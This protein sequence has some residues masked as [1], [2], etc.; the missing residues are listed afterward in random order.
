MVT[1]LLMA[2][3]GLNWLLVGAFDVNLV[4]MLLGSGMAAKGV[5]ILVGLSTI[6]ELVVHKSICTHCGAQ[7]S[8][9]AVPPQM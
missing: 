5:Y 3:G 1:F 6:Y 2:V 7:G 9:P 8:A 4:M